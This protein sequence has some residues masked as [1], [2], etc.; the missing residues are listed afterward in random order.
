VLEVNAVTFLIEG[1]WPKLGTGLPARVLPWVRARREAEGLLREE[2]TAHR[3]A[4]TGNEDV[5]GML[6]AARDENGDGLTDDELVDQLI[7]LLVAGHQ[8]TGATLAWCFERITR[9]PAV[10]ERLTREA[11]D[12]EDGYL[13]AVLKETQRVR[14]P[15]ETIFR[16]LAEPM[17]L[18]GYEV[19]AGT[20]VMPLIRM[21]QESDAYDYPQE[22][23]P[24]RF[25]EGKP[26]SYTWI[27]FGGG[28]RRCV[29]AAFAMLEMRVIVGTVL[30]HFD[31]DV[32]KRAG[33]RR[34]RVRIFTTIPARGARITVR[35][36]RASPAHA[37]S[38]RET[39]A[40]A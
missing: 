36:R 32:S 27:P 19:P 16:E 30:R 3:A 5:L 28:A 18:C 8:T 10:L 2:I 11:R 20:I 15:V 25:L 14:A 34:A 9:H 37:P 17:V 13:D 24:E 7:T 21:V 40:I 23:R 4:P 1:R 26:P 38:D 39:A 35:T 12:G 29:G 33:E 6:I 22:F 31:L